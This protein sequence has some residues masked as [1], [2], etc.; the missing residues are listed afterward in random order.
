[1]ILSEKELIEVKG[2]S[3]LVVGGIL[4]TIVAFLIGLAEGLSRPLI[5]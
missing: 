5:V 1:M 3:K 2:G 4:A